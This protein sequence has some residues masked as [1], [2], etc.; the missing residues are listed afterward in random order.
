MRSSFSR[1]KLG[2]GKDIAV[3]LNHKA[4]QGAQT[5]KVEVNT[6][7][8]WNKGHCG[9]GTFSQGWKSLMRSGLSIPFMLQ[10]DSAPRAG[11]EFATLQLGQE[12]REEPCLPSSWQGSLGTGPHVSS[13]DLLH[14]LHSWICG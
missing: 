7:H 12:P 2:S 13:I 3:T 11:G 8:C 14:G 10:R 5:Q 1:E 9:P 6:I 4:G